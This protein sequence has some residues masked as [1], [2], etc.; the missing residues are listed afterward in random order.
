MRIGIIGL[1]KIAQTKYLPVLL[2]MEQARIVGI[3]DQSESIVKKI[4]KVYRLPEDTG[5]VTVEELIQK[6]PNM[7]F[8]LTHDHYHLAKMLIEACVSVCIEKPLCWSSKQAIEICDLAE[9]NNVPVFAAYMK[10]YDRSFQYL[11]QILREKGAPLSVSAS[12]YAGNNKKWCDPQYH[13]A[14][15]EP[16]EKKRTKKRLEQAWDEFYEEDVI[17]KKQSRTAS[18]LLLQLGIH[19]LNLIRKMFGEIDV[20]MTDV[21]DRDGVCVVHCMLRDRNGTHIQYTLIPLFS[22]TWMWEEKYEIVYPDEIII[23]RPGCPFLI[24]SEATVTVIGGGSRLEEKCMRAGVVEPFRY[25]IED[26]ITMC[27]NGR[28]DNSVREAIKDIELVESIVSKK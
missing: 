2:R 13:I 12:C 9:Q 14:K 27:E 18:Q 16:E 6:K 23:Y 10:Q 3:C 26:I 25:M 5:A 8:I 20:T 24:S 21:Q 15:E 11:M 4:I 19:Q 22:G 1:G 7:V 28:K 17:R